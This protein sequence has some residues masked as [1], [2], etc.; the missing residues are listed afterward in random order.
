MPSADGLVRDSQPFFLKHDFRAETHT[1][2][3]NRVKVADGCSNGLIVSASMQRI[4]GP[5]AFRMQTSV[6]ELVDFSGATKATL[7]R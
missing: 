1:F 4:F 7:D 6:P 5:T 2:Q 3:R